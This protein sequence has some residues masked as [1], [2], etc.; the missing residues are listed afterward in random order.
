MTNREKLTL[1][2]RL[3]EDCIATL[4]VSSKVCAGCNRDHKTNWKQDQA[5]SA[6]QGVVSKL[7]KTLGSDLQDWL[8]KEGT[9]R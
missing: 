2:K 4:D 5:A 8:D 9:V 3:V 7:A 1:A 6:L